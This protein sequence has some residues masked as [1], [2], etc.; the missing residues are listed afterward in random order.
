MISDLPQEFVKQ[1]TDAVTKCK[2]KFEANI[3]EC[4][5]EILVKAANWKVLLPYLGPGPHAYTLP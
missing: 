5:Q 3:T 4:Q 2:Q 1:A